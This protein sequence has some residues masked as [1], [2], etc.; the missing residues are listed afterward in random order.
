V[1]GGG[2]EDTKEIVVLSVNIADNC[3]W[4]LDFK[5]GWLLEKDGFHCRVE[6][7]DLGR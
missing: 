7:L 4:W 5:K 6:K 1:I 2:L 3:D